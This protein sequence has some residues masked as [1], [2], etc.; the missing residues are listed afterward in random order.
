M[1]KQNKFG[2]EE[3]KDTFKYL[4]HAVGPDGIRDAIPAKGEKFDLLRFMLAAVNEYP[5][6]QEMIK[7]FGTFWTEIKDITPEEAKE[8]AAYL[9]SQY[10]TPGEVQEI[11]LYNLENMALT[12]DWIQYN[13]LRDGALLLERWGNK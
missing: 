2:V 1:S 9:R 12:Q 5:K 7:D 3:V 13:V 10:P 4:I 11:V 8:V 6:I